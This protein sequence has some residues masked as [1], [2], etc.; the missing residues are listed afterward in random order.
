MNLIIFTIK[1]KWMIVNWELYSSKNF[2]TGEISCEGELN[3]L[4]LKSY[5]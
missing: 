5:N 2:E 4:G 3:S 1:S